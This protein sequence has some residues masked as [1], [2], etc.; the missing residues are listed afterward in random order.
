VSCPLICLIPYELGSKSALVN[1]GDDTPGYGI[2]SL[3][4]MLEPRRVGVHVD[5]GA[6][7]NEDVLLR[8]GFGP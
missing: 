7:E 6:Y 4:I 1:A 2:G 5:I 3:D 8:D